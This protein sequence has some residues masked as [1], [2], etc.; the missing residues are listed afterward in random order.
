[1]QKTEGNQL[2]VQKI[3]AN[4]S[5]PP[6]TIPNNAAGKIVQ[7]GGANA[8]NK[9]K[10]SEIPAE[11]HGY[12]LSITQFE[13]GCD[14][15]ALIKLLDPVGKC[16]WS[17]MVVD[18]GRS[19]HW[20][21]LGL[22]RSDGNPAN[23]STTKKKEARKLDAIFIS[24]WHSDHFGS[25]CCDCKP[26]GKAYSASN[27]T[28]PDNAV[29]TVNQLPANTASNSNRRANIAP[30]AEV[31]SIEF[32]HV[33]G[34][35]NSKLSILSRR[36]DDD[37]ERDAN[38][39]NMSDENDNIEFVRLDK[40]ND[41]LLN[42]RRGRI[43]KTR[44]DGSV[45]FVRMDKHPSSCPLFKV[46]GVRLHEKLQN[47]ELENLSTNTEAIIYL[48]KG[49]KDDECYLDTREPSQLKISTLSKAMETVCLIATG[50]DLFSLVD[51]VPLIFQK[52]VQSFRNSINDE[53]SFL[54]VWRSLLKTKLEFLFNLGNSDD[55]DIGI[56]LTNAWM[57][58]STEYETV[59]VA[60]TSNIESEAFKNYAADS[61]SASGVTRRSSDELTFLPLKCTRVL[62][63]VLGKDS[64]I[65][66]F[67]SNGGLLAALNSLF[68]KVRN[69]G[70]S[71]DSDDSGAE[72]IKTTLDSKIGFSFEQLEVRALHATIIDKIIE[73]IST[74]V[75]FTL[76]KSDA[77]D[78]LFNLLSGVVMELNLEIDVCCSPFEL[79]RVSLFLVD[80]TLNVFG[81]TLG[82]P[83]TSLDYLGTMLS[84]K[85]LGKGPTSAVYKSDS[86][87]SVA[88]HERE[89]CRP[90][91]SR[92]QWNAVFFSGNLIS[93]W[94]E[95]NVQDPFWWSLLFSKNKVM[96]A[97]VSFSME[98]SHH[99]K[100]WCLSDLS[101]AAQLVLAD[102][103]SPIVARFYRSA[104]DA[105]VDW[106]IDGKTVSDAV[107]GETVDFSFGSMSNSVTAQSEKVKPFNA[108]RMPSPSDNRSSE[109]FPELQT[110]QRFGSNSPVHVVDAECHSEVEES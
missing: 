30:T 95:G 35:E 11:T 48:R 102:S 82:G 10:P 17:A 56:T 64:F 71:D 80:P 60:I 34:N 31:P 21:R 94:L 37:G 36:K 100:R 83:S 103:A 110:K 18:M 68:K 109:Y 65:V 108:L 72:W 79:K 62:A 61:Y 51:P 15:A 58:V 75:R 70:A 46:A 41:A 97:K 49:K 85:Y 3:M 106:T 50:K 9:D 93:S 1:M 14:D 105:K 38:K 104:I 88:D 87:K 54:C 90:N 73:S 27:V 28:R 13:A 81:D 6:A 43:A 91:L 39:E 77:S 32:V 22:D 19:E 53:K 67:L 63:L 44:D 66:S 78:P 20:L 84:E 5:T 47:A 29:L 57:V 12:S 96:A 52:L 69:F 86:A 16:K 33:S 7:R 59:G 98:C 24:H 2:L 25:Y 4:H 92:L 45:E 99:D 8:P 55:L 26:A 23:E 101:G 40:R 76:N 74:T 42:Y 89:V 107:S